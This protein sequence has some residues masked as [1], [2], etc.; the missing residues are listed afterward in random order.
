M[1]APSD[2]ATTG[3]VDLTV[4]P[5]DQVVDLHGDPLTSELTLFMNGNQFMVMDECVAAFQQA[6]PD[7]REVFFETIPPGKLLEQLRVGV[8]QMGAL[9]LSVRPDVVAAGPRSLQPLVD[10]GVLEQPVVYAANDLAILVAA[11]NPHGVTGLADLARPG[12]RVAMPN[13]RYEGVAQ[14]IGQA[15]VR[16]GGEELRSAV[17]EHKSANGETRWTD[18]HHR[19]SA[20]WLADGMVDACPLWST[21]ARYHCVDRGRPMQ[22]VPIPAEHNVT[23]DYAAARVRDCAHPEAADAFLR[24]LGGG[25]RSIYARYGFAGPSD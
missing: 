21:E 24:F 19:E 22:S 3:V 2:L 17:M 7:V 20:Q 10:D 13:L 8:L 1:S 6:H 14:L 5:M 11:G 18:I 25:A 16:A 15:L 9:R 4:P 12:L 23:G